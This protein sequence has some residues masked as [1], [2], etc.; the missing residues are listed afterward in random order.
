MSRYIESERRQL[1]YAGFHLS[2][3]AAMPDQAQLE[4]DREMWRGKKRLRG[5]GKGARLQAIEDVELQKQRAFTCWALE[6][7][8]HLYIRA[9]RW[10]SG[11]EEAGEVS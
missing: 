9:W 4:R 3:Q 5:R 8:G 1:A 6:L 10:S 7:F 2:T 11:E